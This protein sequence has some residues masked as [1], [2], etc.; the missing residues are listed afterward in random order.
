MSRTRRFAYLAVVAFCSG[1]DAALHAGAPPMYQCELNGQRVFSDRPCSPSAQV[2]ARAP[3]RANVY[4]HQS[5]VSGSPTS[6]RGKS[7][8]TRT[9][10]RSVSADD[11]DRNRTACLRINQSIERNRSKQRAGY[12]AKEGV[13]LDERLQQLEE[14]RRV[15][16]CR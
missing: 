11:E 9:P 12:R 4:E 6:V 7:Y 1:P 8:R 10:E 13:R 2:I 5:Y 16:R 3:N 15:R 14:E